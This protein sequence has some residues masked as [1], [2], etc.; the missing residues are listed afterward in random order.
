VSRARGGAKV[1]RANWGAE[2]RREHGRERGGREG[3]DKKRGRWKS[4]LG[5]AAVLAFL[6]G[7][8][9]FFR[10]LA[11][12][13]GPRLGIDASGW[14]GGIIVFISTLVA[15]GV[16]VSVVSVP[17]RR[18]FPDTFV[19][20]RDA[21]RRI[22]SGDFDVKLSVADEKGD[23]PFSG[24]ADEINLMAQSLKR[25]EELRQEFISTVSH[26]IQSPLTSIGGFAKALR[27]EGLSTEKRLHYLSIIEDESGRLSRLS[28]SLLRLTALE[29]LGREPSGIGADSRPIA[30]DAQIRAVVLAAEPQWSAKG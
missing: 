11:Y 20:M 9:T 22:A 8:W 10:A 12:G 28:E 25:M 17:M 7:A 21:I 15:F 27:E 4:F 1:S 14:G 29:S 30:L 13:L 23:H 19:A 26:E 3:Q 5:L 6:G 24:F 18:Q 16:A 2:A